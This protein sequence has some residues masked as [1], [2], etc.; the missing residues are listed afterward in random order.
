MLSLNAFLNDLQ[1]IEERFAK[2]RRQCLFKAEAILG[3]A[4]AAVL[5]LVLPRRL[6]NLLCC[7]D[8]EATSIVSLKGSSPSLPSL[9]LLNKAW[10]YVALSSR[11]AASSIAPVE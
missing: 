11:Q 10:R 3:F 2:F 9:L 6:K 1:V 4:L 5:E 7:F 8:M